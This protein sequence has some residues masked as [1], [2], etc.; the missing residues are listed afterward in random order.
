MFLPSDSFV[1]NVYL[2]SFSCEPI[3]QSKYNQKTAEDATEDYIQR[4]L[5][6]R[7]ACKGSQTVP[8]G[9]KDK[10]QSH[11]NSEQALVFMTVFDSYDNH[12]NGKSCPKPYIHILKKFAHKIHPYIIAK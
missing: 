9:H 4:T 2:F 8:H 3:Y 1:C 7:I 12:K 10:E 5:K 6:H 11:Q